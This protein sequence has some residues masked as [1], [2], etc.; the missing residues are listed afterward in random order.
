MIFALKLFCVYRGHHQATCAHIYDRRSFWKKLS[1]FGPST[2]CLS[3]W[4]RWSRATLLWKP[5]KY[6]QISSGAFKPLSKALAPAHLTMKLILLWLSFAPL[7]LSTLRAQSS[8][9][10]RAHTKPILDLFS[11]AKRKVEVSWV[12]NP[13]IMCQPAAIHGD[14]IKV[15]NGSDLSIMDLSRADKYIYSVRG[16][17]IYCPNQVCSIALLS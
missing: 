12:Y 6:W 16:L 13:E 5:S 3:K 17:P 9:S 14:V 7:V 11:E 1:M 15:A 10:G 8:Y 2:R 4:S